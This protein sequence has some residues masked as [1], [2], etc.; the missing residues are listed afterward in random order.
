MGPVD[1]AVMTYRSIVKA[2]SVEASKDDAS[3]R[4]LTARRKRYW[5]HIARRATIAELV[6]P[7]PKE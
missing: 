2:L 3:Q 5:A 6:D 7:E 4:P 1:A